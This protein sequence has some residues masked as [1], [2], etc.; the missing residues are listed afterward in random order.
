MLWSSE[1]K[2]VMRLLVVFGGGSGWCVVVI[3]DVKGRPVAGMVCAV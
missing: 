1:K 2:D 3:D